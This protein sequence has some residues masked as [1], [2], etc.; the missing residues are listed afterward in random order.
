[1]LD[2]SANAGAGEV[3][4]AYR[5]LPGSAAVAGPGFYSAHEFDVTPFLERASSCL[6]VGRTCVAKDY[7]GGAAAQLL[8]AG[9]AA[10]VF[11]HDVG[12]LFGCASFPGTDARAVAQPLAL[13]HHEHLAPPGIRARAFGP[14]RL[15]MDIMPADQLDRS[16]GMRRMPSL[17]KGYLRL[18][19]F[20]GDGAWIDRDFGVIDVFLVVDVSRVDERRRAFYR[21]RIAGSLA[22]VAD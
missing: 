19:G 18:G 14:N 12:Y 10:Y 13:L 1:M 7:R 9:I 17:I 20:A 15:E 5:M 8:W 11:E 4:G 3:V 2:R 6:E 16:E 22:R 21:D